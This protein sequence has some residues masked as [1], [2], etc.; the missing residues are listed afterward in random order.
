[1]IDF[2]EP[3]ADGRVF[4][5]HAGEVEEEVA[6]L[7]F[8]FVMF[9]LGERV[10]PLAGLIDD[11]FAVAFFVQDPDHGVLFVVGGAGAE[12]HFGTEEG[13]GG[14][15]GE[16][17][18]APFVDAEDEDAAVEAVP[19]F[20]AEEVDVGEGVG[21]GEEGFPGDVLVEDYGVCIKPAGMIFSALLN[22]GAQEFYVHEPLCTLAVGSS[23]FLNDE[24]LKV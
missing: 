2:V 10:V 11:L 4:V 5:F 18:D 19:V 12:F 14:S 20:V 16:E 9:A 1:M 24:R 7:V 13:E 15:F 21:G 23:H 22:N 3:A 6:A 8:E 17:V